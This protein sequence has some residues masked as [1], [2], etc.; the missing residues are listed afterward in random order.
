MCFVRNGLLIVSQSSSFDDIALRNTN[1]DK[2]K[3]SYET[4][5]TNDSEVFLGMQIRS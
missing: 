1:R 3:S 5:L 2:K 4:V